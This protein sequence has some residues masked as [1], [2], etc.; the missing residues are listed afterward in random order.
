MNID[1][2]RND[3]LKTFARET[4]INLIR[5]GVPFEEAIHTAFRDVQKQFGYIYDE[6]ESAELLAEALLES[7]CDG[8]GH[9][10]T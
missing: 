6:V 7:Q 10:L 5:Q 2:L 8:Y 1:E 9:S 3:V 4:A